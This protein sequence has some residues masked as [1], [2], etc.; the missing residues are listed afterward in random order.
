VVTTRDA[1]PA[2]LAG[3]TTVICPSETTVGGDG[4]GVTTDTDVGVLAAVAAGRPSKRTAIAPPRFAPV[5]V[6]ASPPLVER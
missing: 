3:A 4:A 2:A 1:T 6:A 5:M